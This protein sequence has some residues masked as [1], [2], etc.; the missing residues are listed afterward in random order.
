[1]PLPSAWPAGDTTRIHAAPLVAVHVH[2]AGAVT[3]KLR[4]SPSAP[5]V[6]VDGEI[7]YV[8][9]IAAG[10][11][12]TATACPAIVSVPVRTSVLPFAVTVTLTTPFPVL[13]V[14][15]VMD[16]HPRSDAAVQAQFAA[17][18][19]VTEPDPPGASNDSVDGDS[20]YE[21]GVGAGSFGDREPQAMR[22]I[23]SAGSRAKD[24]LDSRI[25]G[26]LIAEVNYSASTSASVT[27]RF[28]AG[29][30][31]LSGYSATFS[32]PPRCSLNTP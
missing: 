23:A 9:V 28:V 5:N 15:A 3:A 18:V 27:V 1:V 7:S 29:M 11:C 13:L 4:E 26:S 6:A 19:T 21:H 17:V 22:T 30:R 25:I 32:T 14:P 10:C 20:V 24:R 16:I 8:H 31:A 12:D 2:E